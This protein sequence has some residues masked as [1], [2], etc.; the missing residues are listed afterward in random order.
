MN[1]TRWLLFSLPLVAFGI[2]VFFFGSAIGTDPSVLPSTRLDKPFPAFTLSGLEDPGQTITAADIKGPVL[3][4]VWATWCPSCIIEH[5]VLLKLSRSGIPILGINYKDESA[6]ARQYL[7]RNGSPFRWNIADVKGDLGLDLGVYGAP[8]TFL[9]DGEGKIRHRFVGAITEN[10][11]RS[12][13][14]PVWQSVGGNAPTDAALVA[15]GE[16]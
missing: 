4:N 12:E 15:G 14:W 11:W 7:Q 16:R 5:P 3:V 10:A 6:A 8:E 2:L 13:L 1:R 9:V